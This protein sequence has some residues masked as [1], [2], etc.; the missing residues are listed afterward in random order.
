MKRILLI[1][2]LTITLSACRF[3]SR[4]ADDETIS[5]SPQQEELIEQGWN[6]NSPTGGEFDESMGVKPIYG[7]QDNYFDIKVGE[8]Y[9]IALKIVD[10]ATDKCIRYVFAPQNE[11]VTIN[12]IPQGKYYIKLAYGNDWMELNT[13]SVTLGKF[14]RNV[15]Y[16]K[17]DEFDFGIKNSMTVMNYILE[18]N[19]IDGTAQNN[20]K[21]ESISEEEFEQN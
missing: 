21:T 16:E 6:A 10:L 4:Q 7:I 20:F 11:T 2:T 13:D 18:I 5:Y 17:S 8:G 9:D 14:T 3:N 19:V 12:Q 15:F 1:L